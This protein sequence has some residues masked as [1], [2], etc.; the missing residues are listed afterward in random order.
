MNNECMWNSQLIEKFPF[1]M[2]GARKHAND[3]Y[4]MSFTCMKPMA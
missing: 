4:K 3:L 1:K 2:L